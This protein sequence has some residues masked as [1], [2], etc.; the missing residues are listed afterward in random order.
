MQLLQREEKAEAEQESAEVEAWAQTES[1]EREQ[2][3][4]FI[5]KY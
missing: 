4:K 1:I 5:K 3:K 2:V